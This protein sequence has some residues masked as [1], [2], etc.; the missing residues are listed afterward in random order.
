MAE[1]PPR[2]PA[3]PYEAG[4]AVPD[5]DGPPDYGPLM[6]V[7]LARIAQARGPV[8]FWVIEPPRGSDALMTG[9]AQQTSKRIER[10]ATATE[11]LYWQRL[12][13]HSRDVTATVEQTRRLG[14]P[15]VLPFP[16]G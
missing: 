14:L 12:D 16:V 7:L 9:V 15:V 1:T 10:A 13:Q 5:G 6:R 2:L 8:E 4:G 11:R 3:C